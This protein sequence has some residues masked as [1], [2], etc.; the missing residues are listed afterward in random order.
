MYVQVLKEN[1][2]L[3][4]DVSVEAF[5]PKIFFVLVGLAK[6]AVFS[7]LFIFQVFT[8]GAREVSFSG[9]VVSGFWISTPN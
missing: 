8:H 1:N 4:K 6:A 9:S 5:Q 7:M 3:K 2:S